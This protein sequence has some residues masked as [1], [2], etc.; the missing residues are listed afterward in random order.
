MKAEPHTSSSSR[1]EG[2]AETR[3]P[4]N[5]GSAP[6]QLMGPVQRLQGRILMLSFNLWSTSLC[7]WLHFHPKLDVHIPP[8]DL[9]APCSNTG[10]S[11]RVCLCLAFWALFILAALHHLDSSSIAHSFCKSHFDFCF[12]IIAP[13]RSATGW[14]SLLS[15]A[16]FFSPSTE[17]IS[18]FFVLFSTELRGCDFCKLLWAGELPPCLAS[19]VLLSCYDCAGTPLGLRPTTGTVRACGTLPRRTAGGLHP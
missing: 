1:D 17:L 18:L 2:S 8:G 16:S 5:K 7:V 19:S 14:C 3:G 11:P 15:P 6:R 12:N 4:Q 9:I 10:L 13:S